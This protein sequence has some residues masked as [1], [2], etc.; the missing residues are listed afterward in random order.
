MNAKREAEIRARVASKKRLQPSQA[1]DLLAALDAA[2]AKA[3]EW[4]DMY[5]AAQDLVQAAEDALD[6]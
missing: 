2:R 3:E 5:S 6:D 4:H 1:R